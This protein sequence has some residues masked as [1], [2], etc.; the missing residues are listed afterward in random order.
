VVTLASSGANAGD[1]RFNTGNSERVRITTNGNMKI[2]GTANRATTVGTN[3]LHI[4]DGTPPV[5]TLANGISIYSQTGEGYI[6]DAA[7][8]GTLQTPHDENGLWV[9]DSHNTVTGRRL[10]V[11]MERMMRA[12]NEHFG[13]D[14]VHE[15]TEAA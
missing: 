3:A 8:N 15:F 1:I 4:F 14:F 11:D 5:G 6:M 7:G 13:W 12:L 9:F 2:A 10:I